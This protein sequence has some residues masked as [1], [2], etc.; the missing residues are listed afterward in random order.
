VPCGTDAPTPGAYGEIEEKE[1]AQMLT[2]EIAKYRIQDRIREGGSERGTRSLV[3][4]RASR[5]HAAGRRVAA[6]AAM[7]PVPFKH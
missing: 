3:E 5:R 6:L 1:V 4:R 2:G 7:V